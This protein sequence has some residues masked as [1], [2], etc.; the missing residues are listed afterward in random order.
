[1][2]VSRKLIATYESETLTRYPFCA[3]TSQEGAKG[4]NENECQG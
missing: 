2:N 4:S 3:S 1:M